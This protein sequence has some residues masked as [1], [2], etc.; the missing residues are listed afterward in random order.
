M[1]IKK[2]IPYECIVIINVVL[3]WKMQ[4]QNYSRIPFI[5]IGIETNEIFE[6]PNWTLIS[7]LYGLFNL[8]AFFNETIK[9]S[10]LVKDYKSLNIFK[11][12]SNY[13]LSHCDC[14]AEVILFTKASVNNTLVSNPPVVSL[15]MRAGDI[16]LLSHYLWHHNIYIWVKIS[17][18]TEIYYIDTSSM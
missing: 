10:S 4:N 12:F 16:S 17:K 6:Y 13:S 3:T 11:T 8:Q 18:N 14:A 9:Q 2:L 1:I 15:R 7:Y 5:Y